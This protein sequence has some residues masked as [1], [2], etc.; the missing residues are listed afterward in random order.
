MYDSINSFQ[1]KSFTMKVKLVILFAQNLNVHQ[2]GIIVL[3]SNS[4]FRNTHIIIFCIYSSFASNL[5]QANIHNLNERYAILVR[6]NRHS[7]PKLFAENMYMY[8]HVS[9]IWDA[10]SCLIFCLHLMDSSVNH[11]CLL[12]SFETNFPK[13]IWKIVFSGQIKC[14]I[15]YKKQ[16]ILYVIFNHGKV[17]ILR[18]ENHFCHEDLFQMG[19]RKWKMTIMN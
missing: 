10:S 9:S 4:T 3:L 6:S 18:F 7:S 15:L 12:F 19:K 16:K 8:Q 11:S 13:N 17:S 2:D 1:P 5:W 14:I